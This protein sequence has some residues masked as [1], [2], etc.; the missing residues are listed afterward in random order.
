VLAASAI[1]AS[2]ASFGEF[3]TPVQMSAAI[4]THC[5]ATGL[6][7]GAAR[8]RRNTLSRTQKSPFWGRCSSLE[9]EKQGQRRTTALQNSTHFGFKRIPSSK[10]RTQNAGRGS[11]AQ[12]V[13]VRGVSDPDGRSHTATNCETTRNRRRRRLPQFLFCAIW[14]WDRRHRLDASARRYGSP[15]WGATI[16]SNCQTAKARLPRLIACKCDPD[17]RASP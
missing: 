17:I 9:P 5:R 14:S 8:T 2:A 10:N 13:F 6:Q 7:I 16:D 11:F 1:S 3:W 12:E 15:G 4:V